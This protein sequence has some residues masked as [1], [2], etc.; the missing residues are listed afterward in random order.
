MSIRDGKASVN[1]C[2]PVKKFEEHNE[3]NRY[4]LPEEEQRLLSMLSGSRLHLRP[5]VQLAINIRK[6]RGESL[7]MCW[8]WIDFP[9]GLIRIAGEVSKTGKRRNVL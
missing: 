3:R 4:L 8:K 5:I 1:P 7:A 6:R 9:R 2:R